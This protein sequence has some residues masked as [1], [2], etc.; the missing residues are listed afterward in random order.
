LTVAGRERILLLEWEHKGLSRENHSNSSITGGKL[1]PNHTK[2][3]GRAHTTGPV[4]DSSDCDAKPITITAT[5]FASIWKISCTI[6]ETLTSTERPLLV[7]EAMKSEVIVKP[8]PEHIGRVV[9][10][11]GPGIRHGALV[12]PGDVLVIL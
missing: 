7:L 3:C 11:L 5:L 10:A 9:K 2:I 8:D 6:G 1:F 4:I 12:K